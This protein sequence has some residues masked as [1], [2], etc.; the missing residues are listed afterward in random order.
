MTRRVAWSRTAAL[1]CAGA[2]AVHELRYLLAFGADSG[3]ALARSGHAYLGVLHPLVALVVGA[4]LAQLMRMGA[5]G[6]HAGARPETTFARAWAM[7]S[8]ALMV[9]Y[10]VMELAEGELSAGHAAGLAAVAGH[11]GLLAVPISVAIGAVVALF[12]REAPGAAGRAHPDVAPR[13]II[14]TPA[15]D[16]PAPAAPA[17]PRMVLLARHLAG[18]APPVVSC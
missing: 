7:A 15:R 16:V 12:L 2:L 6:G 10:S 8:A 17:H 14:V 1:L 13:F 9:I 11:G 18:R 4:V 3:T 5:R